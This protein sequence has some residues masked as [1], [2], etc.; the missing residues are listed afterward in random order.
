ML[1]LVT[2][3]V[4]AFACMIHVPS[5]IVIWL[6]IFDLNIS[7]IFQMQFFRTPVVPCGRSKKQSLKIEISGNKVFLCFE[8]KSS[9]LSEFYM[10]WRFL[11]YCFFIDTISFFSRICD[12]SANIQSLCAFFLQQSSSKYRSS[13]K[14]HRRAKNR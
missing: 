13:L 8:I 14:F 1:I 5:Y 10:S 9:N 2:I 11:L 7:H 4:T 3:K 6:K 12:F